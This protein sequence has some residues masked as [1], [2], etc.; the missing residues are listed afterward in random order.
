MLRDNPALEMKDVRQ[1]DIVNEDW[2][3]DYRRSMDLER[4]K[5]QQTSG[6]IVT[7]KR[8]KMNHITALAEEAILHH[9]P[10]DPPL[11]SKREG[12]AKYGW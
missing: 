4:L 7:E 9:N 8:R 6:L 2:E 11:K 12:G 1:A 10:A 3:E 5:S